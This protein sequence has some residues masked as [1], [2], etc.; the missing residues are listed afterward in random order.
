MLAQLKD[1]LKKIV[2]RL[3][4]LSSSGGKDSL[5]EFMFSQFDKLAVQ[6]AALAPEVV[7]RQIVRLLTNIESESILQNLDFLRHILKLPESID[8]LVRIASRAKSYIVR[9][10]ALERLSYAIYGMNGSVR[11]KALAVILAKRQDPNYLVRYKAALALHNIDHPQAEE[12]LINV[13]KDPEQNYLKDVLKALAKR[14]S[15]AAV[16]TLINILDNP[17]ASQQMKHF[18]VNALGM[19]GDP[20]AVDVLLKATKE[21]NE[22]I[23]AGETMALGS[24]EYG[25]E[26]GRRDRAVDVLGVLLTDGSDEVQFWAAKSLGEI[27]SAK[28]VPKLTEHLKNAENFVYQKIVVSLSQIADT[29]SIDPLIGVLEE[30]R[31][32]STWTLSAA[33]EGLLK[34]GGAKA[35][36]ALLKNL[37]KLNIETCRKVVR[38][39]FTRLKS[40]RVLGQL[41]TVMNG[42][43]LSRF[44]AA[45]ILAEREGSK[46]AVKILMTA[47]DLYKTGFSS[48]AKLL[49]SLAKSRD[50][51]AFEFLFRI[52][53]DFN[54]GMPLRLKAAKALVESE[55]QKVVQ[56]LIKILNDGAQGGESC[57]F[58][59]A[60]LAKSNDPQIRSLLL[61]KLKDAS[62]PSSVIGGVSLG[63]QENGSEKVVAELKEILQTT[64]HYK[65]A[66]RAAYALDIIGTRRMEQVNTETAFL[67]IVLA[68]KS[69]PI[70]VRRG[71]ISG[72]RTNTDN[73]IYG[74]L[75]HIILND[76][77][78]SIRAEAVKSLSLF[79]HPKA[80]SSFL[81]QILYNDSSNIV[82]LVTEKKLKDIELVQPR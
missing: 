36:E 6:L 32:I 25:Q 17:R 44:A 76:S 10:D 28:A 51:E 73:H 7:N 81:R 67:L 4:E 2:T 18:A 26:Q 41:R 31:I 13:M 40:E 45:A 47:V 52:I 82:K 53:G 3:I 80:T 22:L 34:I 70:A 71:I 56:R 1:E 8:D 15:R 5:L 27:G 33:A 50:A 60:A 62:Q 78:P 69:R 58:V 42:R 61:N 64:S 38:E 55:D 21:P 16:P 68:D 37:D 24:I 14:K 35:N 46:K 39:L 48:A 43:G 57:F 11:S 66:K 23:R 77:D 54:Y 74:L 79:D 19:I 30:K 75:R 12:A 59:A 29:K 9:S 72:L 49:S 20:A 65:I 63:L